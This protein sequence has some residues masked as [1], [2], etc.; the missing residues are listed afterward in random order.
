MS[1]T[2]NDTGSLPAP[3]TI[4]EAGQAV[5]R[6]FFQLGQAEHNR[7]LYEDQCASL[8][9]KVRQLMQLEQELRAKATAELDAVLKPKLSVVPSAD[10]AGK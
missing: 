1:N 2:P 3:T 9:A 5:A 7:A 4:Q 6:T 8:R 10:E